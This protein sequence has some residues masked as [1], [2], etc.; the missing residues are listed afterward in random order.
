MTDTSPREAL[1]DAISYWERRRAIYNLA[2][3]VVVCTVFFANLPRSRSALSFGTLEC[4]FVL[5][6]LANVAYCAAHAVDIV[7]QLSTF[8]TRWRRL[9]W[10]LLVIGILFGGVLANSVAQALWP[11]AT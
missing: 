6:V 7:V 1:S 2:L 8:R 3:V 11:R 9:R 5:A 10:V 4:L